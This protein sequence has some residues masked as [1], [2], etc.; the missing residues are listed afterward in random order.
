[1]LVRQRSPHIVIGPAHPRH[2]FASSPLGDPASSSPGLVS[3]EPH[4]Q[5]PCTPPPPSRRFVRASAPE[6]VDRG[7][8]AGGPSGQVRLPR[9]VPALRSSRRR[10]PRERGVSRCP[11]Q[12]PR[13]PR[14]RH[15]LHHGPRR[16]YRA[17][18]RSVQLGQRESERQCRAVAPPDLLPAGRS[19]RPHG[20]SPRPRPNGFCRPS[21][22][23]SHNP[24][25]EGHHSIRPWPRG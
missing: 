11:W 2:R 7:V 19:G 8:L 18:V 10:Q 5:R 16:R 13:R 20:D 6:T 1:M 23:S 9:P 22:D 25:S 12:L 14:D 4:L 24:E 15:G 21:G 17:S 3:R